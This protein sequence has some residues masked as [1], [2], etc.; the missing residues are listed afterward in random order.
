[1][2][3]SEEEKAVLAYIQKRFATGSFEVRPDPY[4]L[5]GRLLRDHGGNVL[6]VFFD[7]KA[8]AVKEEYPFECA[9]ANAY[10]CGRCQDESPLTYLWC[11]RIKD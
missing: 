5:S 8:G 4:S 3:E 2:S 7:T 9:A 1:M 6:S 11:R 10:D